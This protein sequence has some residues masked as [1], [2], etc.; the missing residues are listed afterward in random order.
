MAARKIKAGLKN[1][2][3]GGKGVSY[4]QWKRGDL[5]AELLKGARKT[6]T[7]TLDRPPPGTY[8]PNVDVQERAA[9]RG[10]DYTIDDLLKGRGRAEEDFGLG[11]AA[12][13]RQQGE[14]QRQYGENLDDLIRARTQGQQDYQSNLQT[15][16]RNF[17][18]Q[19]NV[20]AQRGRQAGLAGGFGAQAQRKRGVNEAIERAPVDVNFQRFIEGS[21]LGERRLGEAKQRSLDDVSRSGGQLAL[22]YDR[23][24]EDYGT[25]EYRAGNELQN[26]L[27]D[28]AAARQNQYGGPLPSVQVARPQS[29][30]ERSVVQRNQALRKQQAAER[31]ARSR[32]RGRI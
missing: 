26:Y 17:Q 31:R 19:G 15:I 23:G 1:T 6:K 14:V 21:Q 24:N 25:T 29:A 28:A 18:R 4:A 11:Q 10:Y 12:I 5:L 30:W 22:S 13:E 2:T 32:A 27:Q 20:Q 8:D 3:I 16:A 7:V 9:R